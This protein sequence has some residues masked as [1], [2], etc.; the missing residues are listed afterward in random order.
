MFAKERRDKICEMMRE[1]GA[2]TTSYLVDF[3]NV[4]IETIRRDLLCLEESGMLM[5]VHGGAVQ[6]GEMKQYNSLPL[7]NTEQSAQK[8]ELAKKAVQNVCEGDFIIVDSGSTAIYFAEELKEKFSSLT[9]VT[10]SIDVFEILRNHKDF[11]VILCGGIFEKSENA[12]YGSL[13]LDMLDRLHV[14][15]A[16]ICP[17]AV[18]L[19]NGI[20]DYQHNLC[21]VQRKIM[22][23]SDSIFILADSS[24]FESRALFKLSDMKTEY[25][26]ITDGSLSEKLK[27]LYV[28]NGINIQTPKKSE[29]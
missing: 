24:K 4:S 21:S 11:S 20:Y 23:I 6:V 3:F 13:T 15:K 12:F 19:E 25:V 5:R 26:Y 8:R 9:V 28:E 2:V 7:R 27:K 17:S 16:F 22:E 10:Y 29:C 18:S 1:N 14:S